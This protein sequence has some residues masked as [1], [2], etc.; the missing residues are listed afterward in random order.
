MRYLFWIATFTAVLTALTLAADVPT[1][2]EVQKLKAQLQQTQEQLI[3]A[4]YQ[5]ATCQAQAQVERLNAGR[6]ALERE[7]TQPGYE[8]DWQSLTFKPKTEKK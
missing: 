8:F 4:Q 1:L 6:A 3:Q 5:L 7:L 2:T